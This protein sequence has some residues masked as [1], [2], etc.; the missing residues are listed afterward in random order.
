MVM[1]HDIRISVESVTVARSDSPKRPAGN[2]G[3]TPFNRGLEKPGLSRL[4]H[5]QKF[6]GSNPAPAT[7]L[8][9]RATA[10]GMA[11]TNYPAVGES[12]DSE[13]AAAINFALKA[14]KVPIAGPLTNSEH[15]VLAVELLHR[16]GRFWGTK[17]TI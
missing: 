17:R 9:A 11:A 8:A 2:S 16:Y 10:N 5:T 6:A 13:A 7:N 14:R 15:P 3:P 12:R 1:E 4:V